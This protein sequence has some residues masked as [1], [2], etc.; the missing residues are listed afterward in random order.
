M[1]QDILERL[2]ERFP[3]DVLGIDRY[4][5]DASATVRPEAVRDVARFVK[6]D[7]ALRFDMP[8]DVTAVDYIG[9]EPRF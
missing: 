9:Q 8:M 3:A 4:R 6:D 2:R 5:G 7:P 1:S